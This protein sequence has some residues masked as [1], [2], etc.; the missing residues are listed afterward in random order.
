[1]VHELAPVD[2]TITK[3]AIKHVLPAA[4]KAA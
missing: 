4:H 1:M 3:E 2:A